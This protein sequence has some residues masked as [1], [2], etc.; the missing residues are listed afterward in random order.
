[1]TFSADCQLGDQGNCV[2]TLKNVEPGSYTALYL[3][4][5]NSIY[6]EIFN[7][8]VTGQAGT[9][10][11]ASTSTLDFPFGASS[12]NGVVPVIAKKVVS[13]NVNPSGEA[14]TFDVLKD[15]KVLKS[16]KAAVGP[17]RSCGMSIPAS[18]I[19]QGNGIY[20]VQLSGTDLQQEVSFLAKSPSLIN[21]QNKTTLLK[22]GSSVQLEAVDIKD[23]NN[24]LLNNQKVTLVIW[25]PK[26]GDY[27]EAT[28][29]DGNALSVQNG[30][31]TVTIP[32]DYFTRS[33]YY[34]VYMKVEDGQQSDFVGLAFDDKDIGFVKSGVL[35]DDY[36]NLKIGQTFTLSLT[37]V[38]D[39]NGNALSEGDCGVNL[40][41]VNSGPVGINVQGT[42]KDGVCQVQVPGGKLTRSGPVL[43]TFNGPDIG[44]QIN[45]SRQFMVLPGNVDS[46]G[47]LNFEYEPVRKSYANTVILGPVTD[48]F[49][50]LTNVFDFKLKVF[51]KD[52]TDPV[53]EFNLSVSDGFAQMLMPASVFQ[54]DNLTFKL[55]DR[56]GNE[57]A[58]RDVDPVTTDEKLILPVFP[59][60]VVSD[61]NVTATYSGVSATEPVQCK[62]TYIRTLQQAQE[63]KADVNLEKGKCQFDWNLTEL[64]DSPRALLKLSVM[65]TTFSTVIKNE[66]GEP[67]NLFVITPQ[68]RITPQDEI[69]PALLSSPVVDKNGLP[70]E[71][72]VMRMEV[73]GKTDEV[74]VINGFARLDLF[75]GRFGSK[76]IR[77]ILD[78]KFLD[79]SVDAKVSATSIAKTN[80]VTI[81]LGN[82]DIATTAEKFTM[83]KASNHV[84]TGGKEIFEF[85]TD[86]CS[87][88]QLSDKVAKT[89]VRT[90][91]Q[92]GTCYVQVE[93]QGGKYDLLFEDNG[94][95]VGKYQFSAVDQKDEVIW[96]Q[97]K[98]CSIQ[99]ITSSNSKIEA[100]VYDGDNQYKF[101]T[102]S[103][104][105]LV[106]IQQN[107]LNPLK[108]Y[109]VE[110]RF[111]D[112]SGED[113]SVFKEVM[114]ENL[115]Q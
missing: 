73:N 98:P 34:N 80:D 25:H 42:I 64:R 24:I 39:K 19:A 91:W 28:N 27:R 12:V 18:E 94:F 46:L 79:L 30:V 57:L 52:L 70:V 62:L 11:P 60:E 111:K 67:T 31:F 16:F 69:Q 59:N 50:N 61:K 112:L 78:H 86:A 110:I 84:Y 107:G 63:E 54:Y 47:E 10:K 17:E 113:V 87:V 88:L 26:T 92:G 6:S 9:F 32:S 85:K 109:L 95:T 66:S 71:S 114:G 35:V 99:V 51:P 102:D 41:Q 14:C 100:I 44:R 104:D 90:H 5:A 105:N 37:G 36:G 33:G 68:V 65:D 72:A 48:K 1:V 58:S 7:F 3:D 89:D 4:E 93:G 77:T 22:T 2:S 82:K 76:D 49:G 21:L 101:E 75:A 96:C 103:L 83:Q 81:Y 20:T 108:K 55:Y 29:I 53:G 38:V 97:A 115:V 74:E 15:K 13:L 43:A 45:Q 56:D 106:K 8:S 40:Y 23:S